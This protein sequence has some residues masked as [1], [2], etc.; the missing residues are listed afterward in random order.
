MG[1]KKNNWDPNALPAIWCVPDELWAMIVPVL[2]E[3]DPPKRAGRPRTDPR[4]ILDAI[5]FRM[6]TGVQWN[7]LP[8]EFPDD[9]VVHA[10][11]QRWVKL[12]VMERIWLV[13]QTASDELGGVD[14]EWQSADGALRKARTGGTMLAA[15]PPTA[16]SKG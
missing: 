14:W 10:T 1:R 2:A 9:S 13:V 5:I 7:H 4:A 3:L 6:R 11:F 12:G 8:Q 15:T 16:A